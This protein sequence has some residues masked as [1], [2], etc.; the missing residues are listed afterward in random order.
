MI[1]IIKNFDIYTFLNILL[2]ICY[3]VFFCLYLYILIFFFKKK[4]NLITTIIKLNYSYQFNQTII[5]LFLIVSIVFICHFLEI[6]VL[7]I[8]IHCTYC[9]SNLENEIREVFETD[10]TNMLIGYASDSSSEGGEDLHI[11]ARVSHNEGLVLNRFSS[12][13]LNRFKIINNLFQ[14]DASYNPVD[15][16]NQ[17]KKSMIDMFNVLHNQASI[18]KINAG[19]HIDI[20][21][22]NFRIEKQQDLSGELS[23]QLVNERAKELTKEVPNQLKCQ[24][25]QE[26]TNFCYQMDGYLCNSSFRL[27]YLDYPKVGLFEEQNSHEIRLL[28][29]QAKIA[30]RNSE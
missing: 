8:F 17:I 24:T 22:L 23:T 19:S 27:N 25:Y 29:N 10:E 11:N 18:Q 20:D 16:F 21:Y 3:S 14:R 12:E 6:N 13:T 9:S 1:S 26:M 7:N 15:E 30:A 2:S 28:T 4:I 5:G